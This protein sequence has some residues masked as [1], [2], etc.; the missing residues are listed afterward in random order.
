M[1]G[2]VPTP[3]AI[4]D[5]MVARLLNGVELR[6]EHDVL[7]PGCASGPFI[8]GILRWCAARKVAP[9]RIVGVELD[10]H[11]AGEARERFRDDP[12]VEIR[13]QDFLA[14][15]HG[16]F[17]FVVGNPPYVSIT[18]L[19]SVE[20][21]RY[22]RDYES[23][24]GRFDL[25]LLFFEQALRS[26]RDGGRLVFITPEK[27][28]YTA[29]AAPL[30]RMLARLQVEEV[31]LVDEE[32]FSGFV[33]YPTITTVT[34]RRAHDP[35]ILIDRQGQRRSVRLPEGGGSWQPLL[36][37]TDGCTAGA[38]LG[39]IVDRLSCGV[40][41][42]ADEVFVQATSGLDD[43]LRRFA[44]PTIAGRQLDPACASWTS[45]TSILVPYAASG[46]LLPEARLG[47]LRA[48]LHEPSRRAKL[49]QRTCTAR[50]PWYAFHD[51]APLPDILRPKLLCKD[52]AAKPHFWIDRDGTL[53]PRHSVYYIVPK[54]PRQLEALRDY[55]SSEDACAWLNAHCQRAANG[56]LRL[57][58]HV[59]KRLPIPAGLVS[60]APRRAGSTRVTNNQMELP[61][62]EPHAHA[63]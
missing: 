29:T 54:D 25:Y 48:F 37:G 17:D 33:T 35:T 2:F 3:A 43:E 45:T 18:G 58:S 20:R 55:L 62:P 31:R 23:A 8:E 32:T 21:E 12:N 27:F 34:K 51:N 16:R 53:V 41:T 15:D 14:R 22:R 56:F 13:E 36:H 44:Y 52:I 39:D 61:M 49:L 7:D 30:R 46:E 10:P 26:L 19:S 11:R 9:P 24:R 40:A 59:L 42:G 57:Q 50:K 63:V 6:P 38:T 5:V 4:V 60:V 1:K 47:A 28:L